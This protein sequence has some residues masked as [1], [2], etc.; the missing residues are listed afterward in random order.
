MSIHIVKNS[1]ENTVHAHLHNRNNVFMARVEI[2]E[3]IDYKCHDTLY[4][5]LKENHSGLLKKI[6]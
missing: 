1:V 5:F 6:R 3:H 4:A 2:P